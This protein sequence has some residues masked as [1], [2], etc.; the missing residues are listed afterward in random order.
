MTSMP[1]APP[2]A[3][4]KR[5]TAGRLQ[6]IDAA[7]LAEA[8]NQRLDALENDNHAID[9]EAQ[10][11]HGEKE[12]NPLDG[13]E[14]DEEVV[15]TQRTKSTKKRRKSSAATTAAT[16]SKNRAARRRASAHA[17]PTTNGLPA[18][19]LSRWNMS[20]AKMLQEEEGLERP[21]G[22]PSYDD[23]AARPSTRPIRRFCAVCGYAAVYT[24]PR[25]ASRF[26]SVRCGNVHEQM[27]CMKMIT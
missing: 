18:S 8:S 16:R 13:S 9:Q 23:I 2:R 10:I 20:L 1:S 14:D 5:K 17:A 24:C 25:C 27:Q 4:R 26:C 19:S 22:M 12:Y 3:Q 6:N 11:H 21:A 15:P 7:T